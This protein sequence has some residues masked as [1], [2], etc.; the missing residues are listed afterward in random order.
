MVIHKY[1]VNI[2][3]YDIE[4]N[5]SNRNEK[6]NNTTTKNNEIVIENAAKEKVPSEKQKYIHKKKLLQMK[7]N[8]II[9]RN[10]NLILNKEKSL[11]GQK[12]IKRRDIDIVNQFQLNA[13]GYIN[14]YSKKRN[15][16]LKSNGQ[17][18]NNNISNLNEEEIERLIDQEWIILENKIKNRYIE[19][20]VQKQ[21]KIVKKRLRNKKNIQNNQKNF[22]NNVNNN[23]NVDNEN[24]KNNNSND[25]DRENEIGN[26]NHENN[27]QQLN[28]IPYI[29]DSEMI[30][31]ELKDYTEIN[32]LT[33][34][35]NSAK[36]IPIP[37]FS[38]IKHPPNPF[39]IFTKDNINDIIK[40]NPTMTRGQA[41][42]IVA[43]KW[44]NID[45][46]EKAKY[47][48]KSKEYKED[49][50][51]LVRY[52]YLQRALINNPNIARLCLENQLKGKVNDEIDQEDNIEKDN[53]DFKELNSDDEIIKAFKY[54]VRKFP[55]GYPLASPV[56]RFPER[57]ITQKFK[58]SKN[59]SIKNLNE[60]ETLSVSKSSVKININI[61][62]KSQAFDYF[63][64]DRYKIILKST[65]TISLSDLFDELE[66]EWKY[67]S[68]D[69]KLPYI[70]LEIKDVKR[71][72]MDQCEISKERRGRKHIISEILNENEENNNEGQNEEEETTMVV[73]NNSLEVNKNKK[74]QKIK[75]VKHRKGKKQQQQQQQENQ[76]YS[77]NNNENLTLI[78]DSENEQDYD[79]NLLYIEQNRILGR[80]AIDDNNKEQYHSN[81][82]IN[83]FY[84]SNN[85]DNDNAVDE[86]YIN[87]DTSEEYLP[88]DNISRKFMFENLNDDEIENS[89][90]KENVYDHFDIQ[91]Q[92][93]N[94]NKS[95]ND[96]DRDNTFISVA[97]L[98]NT[99][100]NDSLNY[101]FSQ[102]TVVYPTN[103]NKINNI[104]YKEF[105]DSEFDENKLMSPSQDSSNQNS[106]R[107]TLET[108][109][110]NIESSMK[111]I[112]MTSNLGKKPSYLNESNLET[113][114]NSQKSKKI[115]T[116]VQSFNKSRRLSSNIPKLSSPIKYKISKRRIDE[117]SE[118]ENGEEFEEEEIEEVEESEEENNN[119]NITKENDKDGEDDEIEEIPSQN[120]IINI[121]KV[122]DL[123]EDPIPNK[124]SISIDFNNN[125][126]P[127]NKSS[128]LNSNPSISTSSRKEKKDIF[129]NKFGNI[130]E[131]S[132]VT[133]KKNA[134]S[135][136]YKYNYSSNKKKNSYYY[137]SERKKYD[138]F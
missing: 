113:P 87:S 89:A 56:L 41:L 88:F 93:N 20:S 60:N 74:S 51:D 32:L 7:E 96:N 91:T 128:N 95:N 65:P 129:N 25:N 76:H 22:P 94:N 49:Y 114:K 12:K 70:L 115:S 57:G 66:K 28:Y 18:N 19:E 46:E 77:Y 61:K 119:H 80:N 42:K 118:E 36:E 62:P 134:K 102:D 120:K 8:K 13:L 63:V 69:D 97:S 5:N 1:H 126:T 125:K 17:N 138:L 131:N 33:E 24:N 59:K 53:I 15:E 30:K 10:I 133:P 68:Y 40:K 67:L 29:P 130:F 100:I 78:E 121:N 72:Y 44:K 108:P 39:S 107:T 3:I 6:I 132:F 86:N 31:Q 26:E 105:N 79:S 58:K 92:I 52:A 75:R 98:A 122:D 127:V 111:N 37:H 104:Q 103:E 50:E 106:E 99:N 90:S 137:G 43:K 48:E 109:S 117:E 16:L 55:Q 73:G 82:N 85:N 101:S 112:S 54:I 45:P 81:N 110:S 83:Q 124:T 47:I 135:N 11:T 21:T 84:Y 2:Y 34:L 123:E 9:E 14:F 35:Y 23:Q 38:V 4:K 116:T 71:Y 136:K 27:N 64:K